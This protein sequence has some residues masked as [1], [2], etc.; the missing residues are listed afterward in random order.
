LAYAAVT[1]KDRRAAL[2]AEPRW[3]VWGQFYGGHRTTDG[4][5]ASGAADT[6]TRT[7]GVATGFDYRA[8]PDLVVGLA[9]AG[10]STNFSVANGLGGGKSDVFQLG[11]YG[12][13]KFGAAYLSAAL[14]YAWHD[15][16]TDRTVTVSGI[17]RLVAD[18][19][20]HSFGGRLE[21]GYR[22]DAA[23]LSVTPYAAVQVQ[24]FRT[25][26]YGETAT[27]GSNAFALSYDARTVN[28]TRTE[29]GAWF[30][31]TVALEQGSTVTW[32]ARLAWAHDFNNDQS[33]NVAF[34]TLP[35]ASFTVNG[36]Q[37]A[38]NAALLSAGAEL[39]LINNWSVA[40]KLDGELASGARTYAGTGTLRYVW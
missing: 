38:P 26:A 25:S 30:D 24:A 31:K 4:D 10:G 9:L 15:A 27:L 3:G 40:A 14:S 19:S 29:I 32:R 34:Q 28:A 22:Y 13:K 6:T 17:D 16:S 23:M 21:G 2:P 33:I 35:G 36:A 39:R 20:A 8:A 1:P 7:Y 18:F 37:A 5:A 11:V 12:T